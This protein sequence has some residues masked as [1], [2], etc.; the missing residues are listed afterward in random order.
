M[1]GTQGQSGF[2]TW[3]ISQ[4]SLEDLDREPAQLILRLNLKI[5]FEISQEHSEILILRSL[6]FSFRLAK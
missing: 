5:C 4:M 3:S 1:S 6:V 2:S